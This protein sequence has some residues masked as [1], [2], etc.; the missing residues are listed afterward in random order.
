MGKNSRH[1]AVNNSF[2]E[3]V[4]KALKK[5]QKLGYSGATLK[6]AAELIRYKASKVFV[7]DKEI[8]EFM[9]KIRKFGSI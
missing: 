5:L 4:E 6:E 3:E 8:D 7:T 9:G 2:R 1:I